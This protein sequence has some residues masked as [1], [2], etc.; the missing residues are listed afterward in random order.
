MSCETAVNRGVFS[1]LALNYLYLPWR[2]L[3]R[4]GG[5][6]YGGMGPPE[7]FK[8]YCSFYRPKIY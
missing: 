8:I 7:N 1:E 6:K 5:M 2:T 3:Q 4:C